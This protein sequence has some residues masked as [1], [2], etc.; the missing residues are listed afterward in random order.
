MKVES[1]RKEWRICKNIM[2]AGVIFWLAET[3]FFLVKYGWHYKAS[4]PN[5]ILCDKI[6]GYILGVAYVIFFVVAFQ[7]IDLIIRKYK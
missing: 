3:T 5:E 2:Y 7:M 1:I 6:V 4:M